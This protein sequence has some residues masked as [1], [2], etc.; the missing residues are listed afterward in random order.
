MRKSAYL[1]WN[2]AK[3]LFKK[4]VVHKFRAPC[5]L[6]VVFGSVCVNTYECMYIHMCIHICIYTYIYICICIYICTCIYTQIYLH[7]RTHMIGFLLKGRWSANCRDD[8]CSSPRLP[9]NARQRQEL[10]SNQEGP[11]ILMYMYIQ[12]HFCQ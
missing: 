6:P 4:T 10:P 12:I 11:S 2:M 1:T 5:Q 7:T 3:G 8:G 9:G